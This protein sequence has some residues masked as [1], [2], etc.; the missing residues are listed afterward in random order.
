VRIENEKLSSVLPGGGV[1]PPHERVRRSS[2]R[3]C[4][5]REIK[6]G[7]ITEPQ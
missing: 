3:R 7:S 6:M 4:Q 1:P 5:A 2:K